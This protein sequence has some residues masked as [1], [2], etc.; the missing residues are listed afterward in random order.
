MRN[1]TK[2]KLISLYKSR[3]DSVNP[4]DTTK[5]TVLATNT[6]SVSNNTFA[7]TLNRT[8]DCSEPTLSLYTKLKNRIKGRIKILHSLKSQLSEGAN[9]GAVSPARFTEITPAIRRRIEENTDSLI[10]QGLMELPSFWQFRVENSEAFMNSV[11]R[12]FFAW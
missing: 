11:S 6:K 12:L 1:Y 4:E 8:I 5:R 9:N 3:F 10:D 7:Q 2:K